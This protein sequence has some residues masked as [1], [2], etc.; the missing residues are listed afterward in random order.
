MAKRR[1]RLDAELIR[2][3]LAVSEED[4]RSLIENKDVLVSG[5]FA[6]NPARSVAPGEPVELV[7]PPP[8]FVSRGGLKLA[9]A[10]DRFE[11]DVTGRRALD[12]GASTGG[13]TDCL[14][15]RGVELVYAI[16]VGINQL[17][18]RLRADPRVVSRE[19]F[20]L[21][22]VTLEN[23][24]NEPFEV[25]V[26]D[27]SFTSLKP[28]APVLIERVPVKKADIILLVKPQFEATHREASKGAGIISDPSVWERTLNEVL[29][30]MEVAGAATM[31]VMASPVIGTSGNIEFLTWLKVAET[32]S[33][34][35]D[36]LVG[37]A[38]LEAI[39]MTGSQ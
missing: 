29:A 1:N 21:R 33:Q 38:V 12:A 14:L 20:N 9:S 26:A 2:R 36:S 31:G 22:D 11:I 17:H 10:L 18:E 34:G 39:E 15:K 13:F 30:A 32:S 37:S 23:S 4:A 16:D 27:L 24:G 35:R 3:G 5:F 19:Q 25:V 6:D 28:M 8:E 7:G